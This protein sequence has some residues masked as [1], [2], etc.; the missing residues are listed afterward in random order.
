MGLE[1]FVE[2][3]ARDYENALREIRNG[4]KRS[5]WMWYIFPQVR[6]LGM[7]ETSR[8]YAIQEMGEATD[9]LEH[10]LLNPPH[11]YLPCC[12]TFPPVGPYFVTKD[13]I[14][15]TNNLDVW[16]KLNGELKQNG[17]T[18][19]FIYPVDVLAAYISDFFGLFPGDII[20]TGSPSGSGIGGHPPRFMTPG[21][22]IEYGIEG[23][24]SARLEFRA[25]Q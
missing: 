19:N 25:Y 7:T 22:V 21:D 12:N 16:L 18:R 1:R 4:K 9:Y 13:E 17:N 8:Y 20:S 11:Q 6:G 14:P 23:L 2:A 15:D 3:Q 10:K 5:H 24:G